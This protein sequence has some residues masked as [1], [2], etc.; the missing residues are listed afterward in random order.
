MLFKKKTCMKETIY[1]MKRTIIKNADYI[2]YTF[3]LSVF[4]IFGLSCSE[5]VNEPFSK[6]GGTPP[7]VT[8]IN[9]TNIPGGAKITYNL[10]KDPNLFYIEAEVNT[11][12]GKSFNFKSSSYAPE[13]IVN[14]LASEKEQE[15]I[16]YSVNK[17]GNRSE[18]ITVKI[19]PLKPPYISVFE[20][21]QARADFEGVEVELDNE[22]GETIA[23]FC[24]Y[25]D[26]NGR[27]VDYDVY[28]SNQTQKYTFMGLDTVETKFAFYIR[29]KWDNYSDTLYT[30]IT[31]LVAVRVPKD[32]W[33]EHR[34]ESDGP[35][36]QLGDSEYKDIKIEHLWDGAWGVV[37]EETGCYM[38][39]TPYAYRSFQFKGRTSEPKSLTID[40]GDFYKVNRFQLHHYRR[41]EFTAAKRWEVWGWGHDGE[42]EDNWNRW[43]LLAEMEQIKPS[44]LPEKQYGLGDAEEWL[45]GSIAKFEGGLPSMRYIRIRA[46]ESWDGLANFNSAEITVFGLSEEEKNP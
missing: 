14:G 26:E 20:K 43:T 2:L 18:P 8:N 12:E 15:V 34:L 36:Y 35:F 10:P 23:C 22:S 9:I 13:V 32:K 39:G 5:E 17:S 44:G 27:F 40:M 6:E 1:I 4:C 31:P 37:F 21:L 29:D 28:Y 16:L 46:L 38:G 7:L 30:T 42:P 45:R 19:N 25:I 41:Y 24:A 3:V 33:K 11:P